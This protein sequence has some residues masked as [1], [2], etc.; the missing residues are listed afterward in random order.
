VKGWK[1][2]GRLVLVTLLPLLAGCY[3]YSQAPS[4][5]APGSDLVLELNDRGRVGMGDSIGPSV[6][7]IEGKSTQ[8]SDSVFALKVSRVGYLTGQ[9]NEWNGERLTVPKPFVMNVKERRFSRSR[10]GIAAAGFVAAV[11]AFIVT[12]SILGGGSAPGEG[13]PGTGN[14]Q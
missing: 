12:R 10:S 14:Q 1:L 4:A 8:L 11:T 2:K 3:V 6:R 7:T 5:P 13:G 9:V